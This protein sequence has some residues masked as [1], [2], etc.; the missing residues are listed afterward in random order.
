MLRKLWILN[1]LTMNYRYP[2]LGL[3]ALCRSGPCPIVLP[4]PF[5]LYLSPHTML[6]L[7]ELHTCWFPCITV[8]VGRGHGNKGQ[9]LLTPKYVFGIVLGALRAPSHL[10]LRTAL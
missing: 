1:M 7:P 3:E 8:L 6:A 4:L 9:H 2:C 10:L 5:C